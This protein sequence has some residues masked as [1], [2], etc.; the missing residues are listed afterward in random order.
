MSTSR[1]KITMYPLEAKFS[2]VTICQT[3]QLFE[4]MENNKRV[5]KVDLDLSKCFMT[6]NHRNHYFQVYILYVYLSRMSN[7]M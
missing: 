4:R 6:S 2:S 1:T 3:S 7:N 5:D